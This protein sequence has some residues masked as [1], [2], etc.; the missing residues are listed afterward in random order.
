MGSSQLGLSH[1]Q[2]EVAESLEVPYKDWQCAQDRESCCMHSPTERR[3]RGTS[4]ALADQRP[5]LGE[6]GAIAPATARPRKFVGNEI[7][8][9]GSVR[10]EEPELESV[11]GYCRI[12]WHRVRGQMQGLLLDES[13]Q[14]LADRSCCLCW[15]SWLQSNHLNEVIDT[16]EVI[17]F[18]LF[19]SQAFDL[20]GNG[21]IRLFLSMQRQVSI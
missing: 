15:P 6:A 11:G 3:G 5:H 1:E 20:S 16:A 7:Q 4:V 21:R 10:P 13:L 8:R 19:A 14:L 18:E 12:C 9:F 17:L 2:L